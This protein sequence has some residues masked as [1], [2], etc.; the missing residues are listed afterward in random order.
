MRQST[1]ARL[2]AEVPLFGNCFIS[3]T[4]F[5]EAAHFLFYPIILFNVSS[6]DVL[7][8]VGGPLSGNGRGSP[9]HI[10]FLLFLFTC[11]FIYSIYFC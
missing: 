8:L 9:K 5:K 10:E 11:C 3:G 6:P 4:T 7:S 2:I 1:I